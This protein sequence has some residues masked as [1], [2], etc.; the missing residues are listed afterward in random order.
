MEAIVLAGGLGKR[1]RA[2][3]SDLPKPMAPV[4]ERPFLAYVLSFL[5]GQGLDRVVLAT[6]YLHHKIEEFFGACYQ[7]V[8]IDYSVEEEPLGTGGGLQLAF[9]KL[10]EKSVVIVNGDTFFEVDLKEMNRR[11]SDDGADLTIALKP[12]KDVERYGVVKFANGQITKFE[13]KKQ[14]ASGH[15]NTDFSRS[16]EKANCKP[17]PG[18]RSRC[19]GHRLFTP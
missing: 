12:M 5:R 16:F 17:P 9:S 13:E 4:N 3:I 19:P 6:G 1:L 2:A 11:H 15:I 18:R 8:K 7:D 10:R 14:V